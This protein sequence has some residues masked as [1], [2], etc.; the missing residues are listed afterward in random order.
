MSS[1]STNPLVQQLQTLLAGGGYNFYD[2]RNR[3]RADD[4]L[5]RQRASGFLTDGAQAL[6]ALEIAYRRQFI[7]PAT[8]DI[9]YPPAETLERL[10]GI[11]RLRA[12]LGDLEARIRGMAVPTQDK[13]WWRFREEQ[14]LLNALL[15]FDYALISQAEIIA[16]QARAVTPDDW[17]AR[18]VP[19]EFAPPL[20]QLETIVRDRQQFLQMPTPF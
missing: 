4:L 17:Q 6:S 7:P 20:A 5:V 16:I 18:D 11:G 14:G 1:P 15:G 10:R 13:V 19:S 2:T 8:R 9:P 12:Q 3:A